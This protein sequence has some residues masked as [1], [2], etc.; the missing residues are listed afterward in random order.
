M[1][2]LALR[3][4]RKQHKDIAQA[5]DIIVEELYKVFEQAVFHGGTAIWRCYNGNRFSED[6]DIYI[7]KN[8]AKINTLF[9]NL[10]KRGFIITK[11]R[12][13]EQSL[14]STLEFNRA[15]VRFEAVFKTPSSILGEY[16]TIEGSIITVH[17][18]S[19][20]DLIKEKVAAYQ[21]RRKIRDLYD[22]FYLLRHI[23]EIKEVKKQLAGFIEKFEKPSDEQDLKVIIIEGLVP[24]VQDMITYIKRKL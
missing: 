2:P 20:E 18:L 8:I 24:F 21:S 14:Y 13:L 22:I 11:K 23:K 16:E 10:E 7:P 3:I 4:K 12:V 6:I 5:Q 19:P 15:I 9:E 1:I 17:T